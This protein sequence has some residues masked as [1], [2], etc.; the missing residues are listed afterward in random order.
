[1][2]WPHAEYI[3]ASYAAAAVILP[4]LALASLARLR[5]ALR[6][7]AELEAR[8]EAGREAG[9]AGDEA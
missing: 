3:V 1:M 9:A 8:L 6:R 2:S 5:R 7:Q 4:G